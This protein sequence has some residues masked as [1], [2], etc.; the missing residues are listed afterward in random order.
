MCLSVCLCVSVSVSVCDC[1]CVCVSVSVCDCLSVTVCLCVCVCVCVT[2][3]VRVLSCVFVPPL[4]MYLRRRRPPPPLI[5][6]MYSTPPCYA[7][8]RCRCRQIYVR[9][10]MCWSGSDMDLIMHINN[11]NLPNCTSPLLALSFP[12]A[13]AFHSSDCFTFTHTNTHTHLHT[14]THTHLH[15]LTYT[16]TRIR[17]HTCAAAT[18]ET[19][20]TPRDVSD[21]LHGKILRANRVDD[22]LYNLFTKR[23]E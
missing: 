3:C 4:S 17:V 2:V 15:T 7:C 6:H 11:P 13:L 10:Q 9:R 20:Y 18:F 23:M 16:H 21:A 22:A 8:N 19:L 1:V 5:S 12:D 14:Q